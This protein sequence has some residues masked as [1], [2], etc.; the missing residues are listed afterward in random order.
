MKILIWSK[1]TLTSN[2]NLTL[3]FTY[4]S[5]SVCDVFFF[6]LSFKMKFQVNAA[7]QNRLSPSA[8]NY[9]NYI[10]YEEFKNELPWVSRVQSKVNM[11]IF[12]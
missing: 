6:S 8:D 4:A 9:S 7:P 11:C 10:D 5:G 2:L 3:C 1:V 12:S